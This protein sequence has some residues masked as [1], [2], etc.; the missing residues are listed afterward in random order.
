LPR[1]R[2]RFDHPEPTLEDEVVPEVDVEEP[3]GE[4]RREVDLLLDV[5]VSTTGR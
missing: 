2:T 5:V 1:E 3:V 4:V